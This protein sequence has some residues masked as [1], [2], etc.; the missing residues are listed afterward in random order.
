MPIGIESI[1]PFLWLRLKTIFMGHVYPVPL[2]GLPAGTLWVWWA[3]ILRVGCTGSV[4]YSVTVSLK[5]PSGAPPMM[6][7]ISSA[8]QGLL[9]DC[10]TITIP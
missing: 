10:N 1:L 5:G 9:P 6:L 8:K 3:D 7:H 4:Y 2:P